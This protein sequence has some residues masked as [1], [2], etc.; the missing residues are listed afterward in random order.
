LPSR[1]FAFSAEHGVDIS[2]VGELLAGIGLDEGQD[3][4]TD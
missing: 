4:A 3:A 2:P 1:A